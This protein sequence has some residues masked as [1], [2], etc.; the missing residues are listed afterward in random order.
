M[1]GGTRKTLYRREGNTENVQKPR[2]ARKNTN[3]LGD[4]LPKLINYSPTDAQRKAKS[5]L[6]IALEENPMVSLEAITCDQAS[7]L[8]NYQF[9]KVW[10]EVGF[11]QWLTNSN[12]FRE[13]V[14]Y[15]AHLCLDKAEDLLR[16]E[17][18]KLAG[19]Q[20]SLIGKVSEL[21]NK[22]PSRTREKENPDSQF[23]NMSIE[24]I[25]AW[26]VEQ[27]A[28]LPAKAN[29]VDAE[30]VEDEVTGE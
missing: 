1:S 24:Q 21:A 14:E 11:K 26:L 4:T 9:S 29:I 25:Q 2:E 23:A 15:L 7:R 18:T 10:N 13:R 19:A 20:V 12:E 22:L 30:I 8:A 5:R 27:A 6:I 3:Q 16:N 28:Q 17:D